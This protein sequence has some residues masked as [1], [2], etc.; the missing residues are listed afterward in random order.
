MDQIGGRGSLLKGMKVNLAKNHIFHIGFV[1][2]LP[3][4]AL[5]IQNMLYHTMVSAS[6]AIIW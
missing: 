4:L 5:I 3:Q 2:W 6:D 1:F